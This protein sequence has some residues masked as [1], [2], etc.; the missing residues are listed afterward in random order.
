MNRN[1]REG[2]DLTL[3]ALYVFPQSCIFTAQANQLDTIGV[4]VVR[5]DRNVSASWG[6]RLGSIATSVIKIGARNTRA[7]SMSGSRARMMASARVMFR[8]ETSIGA[9]RVRPVVVIVRTECIIVISR[10]RRD[11]SRLASHG[12]ENDWERGEKSRW[13]KRE[14]RRGTIFWGNG[15][16]SHRIHTGHC[17]IWS[18]AIRAGSGSDQFYYTYSLSSR[19][20]A[21]ITSSPAFS[22][23]KC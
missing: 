11:D 20:S 23:R 8:R 22:I 19:S 15:V 13:W 7:T 16:I 4:A 1:I 14:I 5:R 18:S 10:W 17:V 9:S 2:N 3:E 12:D 6:G 21:S